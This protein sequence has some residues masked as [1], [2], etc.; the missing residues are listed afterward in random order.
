ME[1][2]PITWRKFISLTGAAIAIGMT[3]VIAIGKDLQA[4]AI[5]VEGPF[6]QNVSK[7]TKALI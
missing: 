6:F 4:S 1:R 5:Q 2:S 7:S 3:P